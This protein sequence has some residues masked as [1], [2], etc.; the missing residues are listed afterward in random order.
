MIIDDTGKIVERFQKR[1][2]MLQH[3][4]NIPVDRSLENTIRM[5]KT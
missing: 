5:L 4:E 1:I 3:W 2:T